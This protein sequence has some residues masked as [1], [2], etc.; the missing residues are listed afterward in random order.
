MD[1]T[2]KIMSEDLAKHLADE[3]VAGHLE[4]FQAS[5]VPLIRWRRFF[6]G[7]AMSGLAIKSLNAAS[8]N[9]A[10]LSRW[11]NSKPWFLDVMNQLEETMVERVYDTAKEIAMEGNDPKFVQWFLTQMRPE[12][13]DGRIRIQADINHSVSHLTREELLELL[14]RGEDG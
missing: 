12:Q 4:E 9:F 1:G 7:Y 13:F 3:I 2:G 8:M 11:K 10:T 6:A 5:R 14:E